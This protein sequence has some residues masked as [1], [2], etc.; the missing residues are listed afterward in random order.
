MC[1]KGTGTTVAFGDA[2]S[3]TLTIGRVIEI[4][5]WS[6]EV[7][8]IDDHDLATSGARKY[9]AGGIAE[10]PPLPIM[11]VFDGNMTGGM[12]TLGVTY[13]LTV[14]FPAPDDH[15]TGASLGGTGFLRKAGLS[16]VG[17]DRLTADLEFRFDGGTGP[18]WTEASGAPP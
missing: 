17:E 9:C 7:N 1:V 15:A 3:G 10:H 11:C 14:Q 18:T 8:D 4:G 6:L 2:G 12:P 13:D 16:A 5:E